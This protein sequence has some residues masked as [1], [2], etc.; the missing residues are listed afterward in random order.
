[1]DPFD[2]AVAEVSDD[3]FVMVDFGENLAAANKSIAG[4]EIQERGR[5]QQVMAQVCR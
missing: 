2:L 5:A 4:R 1:M 3:G